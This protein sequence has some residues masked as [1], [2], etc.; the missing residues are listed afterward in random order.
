MSQ[1][2]ASTSQ[3]ANL[4]LLPRDKNKPPLHRIGEPFLKGPVPWTWLQVA[5]RL[6]G[7]S[8]H[9]GL[10]LW[11]KAGIEKTLEIQVNLSRLRDLGVSR[12][13]GYRGLAQ[14]EKAGLVSVIR[15]PGGKATIK[16]LG[17]HSLE[18]S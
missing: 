8:L 11:R 13:S 15:R 6:P 16:L 4:R 2:T 9:V 5:A 17:K 12:F 7:K 14:L 1:I 18:T 3:L 10:V